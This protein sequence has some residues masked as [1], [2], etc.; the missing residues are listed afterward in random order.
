MYDCVVE[1]HESIRHR[2]ESLQSKNHEDHIAGKGFTSMTHYN[3]VQKFIPMPQ[4]MNEDS[5][6][7]SCRGQGMEEGH[8]RSTK[9]SNESPLC[10]TDG[11]LSSQK[12]GVRTKIEK[13]QRQSR[14]PGDILKDDSGAYAVWTSS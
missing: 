6:C 7:K 9:R 4:T 14:A 1:S 10:Y 8:S 13:I 5:G 12:C 3:L 2:A 11:H